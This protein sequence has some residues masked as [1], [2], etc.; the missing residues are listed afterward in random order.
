V[1]RVFFICSYV[2]LLFLMGDSLGAMVLSVGAVEAQM[3][4]MEVAV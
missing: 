2:C 4:A 3:V 1:G